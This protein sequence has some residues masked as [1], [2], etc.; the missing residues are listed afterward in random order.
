MTWINFNRLA[1]GYSDG[2]IALWSIRPQQLLSRHAVHH[3]PIVDIV[4]GY[5]SFPYLVASTPVGG[6]TKLVDLRSPSQESSEV[7]TLSINTTSNTMS[8]SDHLLGFFSI[9]PSSSIVNTT[10]AFMHH[11]YFPIPRKTLTV[12]ALP[13]CV[14]V[15]RTHPYLLVGGIDG[16]L[17][18]MNPQPEL[19]LSRREVTEQIRIFQHEYRSPKL[20]P[21]GSPAAARGVSRIV[22]GFFPTK[23][24]HSKSDAKPT[25][26]SNASKA[27]K[28]K[29]TAAA[30]AG[31]QHDEP[32]QNDVTGSMGHEPLSR[33]TCVEWNPNEGYGC[34]AAVSMASGLV[35][36]I[37]LGLETTD[38]D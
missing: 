35:K 6:F 37:D 27:K 11:A 26:T 18:A 3:S 1:I 7:P 38:D 9:V 21:Q 36:V 25:P 29:K 4:S 10:V 23:N 30:G 8:Y 2:S 16:S 31:G 24:S 22:Q 13:T 20:M 5:P 32:V 14:S 33:V 17:W 12:D 28:S 34:W 19:I 15:G